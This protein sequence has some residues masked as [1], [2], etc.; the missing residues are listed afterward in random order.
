MAPIV[1]TISPE[2]WIDWAQASNLFVF[3]VGFTPQREIP[4]VIFP[5]VNHLSP[6]FI[7]SYVKLSLTN[8][9]FKQLSSP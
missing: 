2:P 1:A 6:A 8:K 7:L 4:E 5:R 9:G 3:W